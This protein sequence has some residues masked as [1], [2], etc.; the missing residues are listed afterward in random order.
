[1]PPPP[2][3]TPPATSQRDPS[4]PLS[5]VRQQVGDQ[6]GSTVS[7]SISGTDLIIRRLKRLLAHY[8]PGLDQG[9]DHTQSPQTIITA[10]KRILKSQQAKSIHTQDAH[11][12]EQLNRL[13]DQ[14]NDGIEDIAELE[15]ILKGINALGTV[16]PL[17]MDTLKGAVADWLAQECDQRSPQDIQVLIATVNTL[18]QQTI[19]Q[20]LISN[21][22][23][24]PSD[25]TEDPDHRST[26]P[27]TPQPISLSP[28]TMPMG[29]LAPSPVPMG[30]PK[31]NVFH[32]SHQD[33]PLQRA[34]LLIASITQC[35]THHALQ[36]AEDAFEPL[37]KN[38]QK[39]T[40]SNPIPD[41]SLS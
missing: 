15:G 10:L 30:Q 40:P 25:G 24:L 6:V 16:P 2:I 20:D 14:L 22:D 11:H 13:F 5:S 28:V 21:Q 33:T 32:E 8:G 17:L 31:A 7:G 18:A 36:I 37:L 4:A 1:M 39:N 9:L 26:D 38:R 27:A 3:D 29:I 19:G 41:R 23:T 35:I 12:A 34:A